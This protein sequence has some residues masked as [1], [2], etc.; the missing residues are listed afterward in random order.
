M[1]DITLKKKIKNN[2]TALGSC[3]TIPHRWSID[4]LAGAGYNFI[5]FNIG[6]L[7]KDIKATQKMNLK[8]GNN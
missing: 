1:K 7:F 2:E 4:I 3:A 6:F 5:A 8:T